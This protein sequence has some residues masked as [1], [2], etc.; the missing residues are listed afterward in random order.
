[1]DSRNAINAINAMLCAILETVA[2]CGETPEGPMYAALMGK[3]D[4]DQFH[5]LL[6]LC[7][8]SGL[9]IRS[10]YHTVTLTDKGR[11]TVEKIRA[12]RESRIGAAA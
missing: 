10:E 7:D 6:S 1:M 11:K 12:F 9:V 8:R 2:E 4:L 3:V 5:G